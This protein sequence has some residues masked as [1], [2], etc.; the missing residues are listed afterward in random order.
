MQRFL[1]YLFVVT[2]CFAV[3]ATAFA[4]PQEPDYARINQAIAKTHVLPRYQALADATANFHSMVRKMC[5]ATTTT[6]AEVKAA[7]ITA[8]DAWMRIEH[9][10]F[11]PIE[12]L[13][14]N[15]RI[16]FWPDK[17]GRGQKQIRAL[18][19][20]D[21]QQVFGAGKFRT[22]SVA[23]QGF[24]AAEHLLY[25]PAMTQIRDKS[26]GGRACRFLSA[27]AANLVE[28]GADVVTDW[29]QFMADLGSVGRDGN[30]YE[31]HK[32]IT[33][34]FLQSIHVSLKILAD[35]KLA[36]PA[37]KAIS[38]ARPKRSEAWRSKR[39]L[40]NVVA[41]L[42]AVRS[43]YEGDGEG[44]QNSG[45]RKL[46]SNANLAKAADLSRAFQQTIITAQDIGMPLCEA[47]ESP[48][49]R[50]KVDR[51]MLQVRALSE[52]VAKTLAP[53]IGLRLGFNSLDGD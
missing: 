33:T 31:R 36:R 49:E 53:E 32:E 18:L 46:I 47:V 30:L 7:F 8:L 20:G 40:G 22:T 19:A 45:L 43:L 16:H 10:R 15:F 5:G 2:I 6:E 41:N 24:P 1:V 52:M 9:I 50:P 4:Q 39:S 26:D 13:M 23:V 42:D 38:D 44:K 35:L 21:A 25:G 12:M 28:M 37:G 48:A 34:E 27:I 17:G 51:L 3:V 29:T 11:G 14:R